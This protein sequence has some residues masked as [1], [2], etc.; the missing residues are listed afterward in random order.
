MKPEGEVKIYF[1]MIRIQVYEFLLSLYGKRMHARESV[2]SESDECFL[3]EIHDSY[4]T[5]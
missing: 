4:M 2:F 3:F 5:T 1:M